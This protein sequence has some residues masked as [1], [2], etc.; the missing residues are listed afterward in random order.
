MAARPDFQLGAAG[1]RGSWIDEVDGIELA[2]AILALVATGAVKAAVRAGPDDLA[3][4]Q[5]PTILR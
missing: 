2:R 4:G 3:V 1:E 5:E